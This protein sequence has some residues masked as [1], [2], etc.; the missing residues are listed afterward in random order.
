M[1]PPSK[2]IDV[3]ARPSRSASGQPDVSGNHVVMYVLHPCVSSLLIARDQCGIDRACLVAVL[4][5]VQQLQR[6]FCVTLNVRCNASYLFPS[7]VLFDALVRFMR[8]SHTMIRAVYVRHR[9]VVSRRFGL[10][11]LCEL[12]KQHETCQ[13]PIFRQPFVA[14]LRWR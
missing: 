1:L 14:L 8:M 9:H 12:R 6:M 7:P 11:Y 5:I 13:R 4:S 3:V 2:Y 10:G